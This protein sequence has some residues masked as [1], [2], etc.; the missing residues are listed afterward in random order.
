MLNQLFFELFFSTYL[1]ILTNADTVT[2]TAEFA[3]L[4]KAV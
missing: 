1:S 3:V 4:K 2:H